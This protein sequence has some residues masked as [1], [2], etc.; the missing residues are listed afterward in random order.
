MLAPPVK[1]L[2]SSSTV[3]SPARRRRAGDRRGVSLLWILLLIPG[4][5]ALLILV[6]E[7]SNIWLTRVQLENALEAAALAAV[8]EWGES[9]DLADTSDGRA[10]GVAYALTNVIGED[11]LEI[12]PNLHNSPSGMNPNS[13]LSCDSDTGHLVFGAITSDAPLTFD[14]RVRPSCAGGGDPEP[15][16]LAQATIEVPTLC[17][18]IFGNNFGPF[19]VTAQATA[20]YD[21]TSGRSRLIRVEEY[22]CVVP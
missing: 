16:V 9:S 8:K 1:G 5:L 4:F 20:R 17:G 10:R 14:T 13:N 7:V 15:A 18:Q 22:T 3:P 21:C 19:H 2:K 11:G 6:L 12:L